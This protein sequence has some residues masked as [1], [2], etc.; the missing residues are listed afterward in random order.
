MKKKEK[1]YNWIK[2]ENTSYP[3]HEEEGN[4]DQINAVLV[5]K[6]YGDLED[7]LER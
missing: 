2:R 7:L 3:R 4:S 1:Y 6:G 5:D